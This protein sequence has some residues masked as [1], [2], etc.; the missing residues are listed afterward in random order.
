MSRLG[1]GFKVISPIWTASSWT[2]AVRIW[3]KK[4]RNYLNIR[5]KPYRSCRVTPNRQILSA[6]VTKNLWKSRSRRKLKNK[7]VKRK[8]SKTKKLR[9]N[10]MSSSSIQVECW[11]KRTIRKWTQA[12]TSWLK[13]TLS[14]RMPLNTHQNENKSWVYK[15]S[16]LI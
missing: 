12:E 5:I 11:A 6:K 1:N 14:V 16:H 8:K 15:M 13:S 3:S 4:N 9:K 7:R 2:W 10:R